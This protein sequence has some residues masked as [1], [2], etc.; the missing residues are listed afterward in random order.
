MIEAGGDAAHAIAALPQDADAI[1]RDLAAVGPALWDRFT[2]GR[3]GSLWRCRA[4]A[5]AFSA[6]GP[7][8]LA[9]WLDRTVA[10]I[11]AAA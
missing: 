7:G 8:P 6:A 3:D 4:L 5:D 10:E 11:V 2:G 9:A 1:R